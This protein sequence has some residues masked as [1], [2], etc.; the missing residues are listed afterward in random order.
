MINTPK[1]RRFL[2]GLLTGIG[3]TMAAGILAAMSHT[4]GADDDRITEPIYFVTGDTTN[5]VLWRRNGDGSLTC[6]SR[7]TCHRPERS[8]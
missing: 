7:N 5:A 2:S 8:R 3:I 4:N 6:I 1:T